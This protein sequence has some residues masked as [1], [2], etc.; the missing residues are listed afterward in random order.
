[1]S[2]WHKRTIAPAAPERTGRDL[3]QV[4]PP[5]ARLL[6]SAGF[7]L[8]GLGTT[9]F[10]ARR[11]GLPPDF[12]L[13]SDWD[14]RAVGLFVG[15]LLMG[16]LGSFFGWAVAFRVPVRSARA[17][18]AVSVLWHY[19]ANGTLIWLALFALA[20]TKSYSKEGL[21]ELSR[22][23]G[24]WRMSLY[25]LALPAAGCLLIGAALLLAGL[26]REG[27]RPRLLPCLLVALPPA[28]ALSYFEFGLFGVESRDWV[29]VGGVF[30][31]ALI[32]SAAYMVERD[33]YQREQIQKG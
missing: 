32:V 21:R 25:M 1:M 7:I 6:G 14:L 33:R 9:H 22:E 24:D 23:M 3:S 30:A 5:L 18:Y 12:W 31:F 28:L 16:L 11:L 2:D 8:L 13:T 26:L 19:L 10:G 20:L 29:L 27:R 15:A 4:S 17:N